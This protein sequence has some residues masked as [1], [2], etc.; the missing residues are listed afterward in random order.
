MIVHGAVVLASANLHNV[1]LGLQ[2]RVLRLQISG[3]K[4]MPRTCLPR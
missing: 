1:C 4:C 2:M 3:T